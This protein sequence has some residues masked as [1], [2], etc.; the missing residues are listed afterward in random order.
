MGAA[1]RGTLWGV[2][3]ASGVPGVEVSGVFAVVFP[4]VFSGVFS[5]VSSDVFP[6]VFSE[7]SSGVLAGVSSVEF[8]AGVEAESSAGTDVWMSGP[9]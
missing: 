4:G 9:L 2:I 5:E 6:E 1:T 3:L 8:P 7:V